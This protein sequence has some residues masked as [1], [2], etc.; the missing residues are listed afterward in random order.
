MLYIVCVGY[1]DVIL[2]LRHEATSPAVGT[3]E[4]RT[5]ISVNISQDTSYTWTLII[6]S[7]CLLLVIQLDSLIL[8]LL[9]YLL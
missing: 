5:L 3:F 8:N 1:H 6:I 7:M 9:N 4:T 2:T